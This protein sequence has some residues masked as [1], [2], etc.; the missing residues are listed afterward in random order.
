MNEEKKIMENISIIGSGNVGRRIGIYFSKETPSLV[1]FNDINKNV[2]EEL[3][4]TGYNATTDMEHTLK[5]SDISF[6]AVPTPIADDGL[7]NTSFLENAFVSIGKVL[8]YK[9]SY[10]IFVLKSTVTPGTTEELIIPIIE[11]YSGKIEGKDFGVVFNPEFLTVI[12]NTWTDDKKFCVNS[13]NEGR[14]V[15]GEGKNKKAG[16]IIE[17]FYKGINNYIPV[18]RTDYKTAEM[19]KLV[20][21]NRLALAISFSNEIF[22]SCK[23]MK[24]RGMDIDTNFIIRSMSMDKRIGMYGSIFGKAWGGPCFLKDTVALETFIKNKTGKYPDLISGSVKINDEM[25]EIYD[26][27]E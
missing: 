15:I 22:L 21:N 9:N 17:A 26:I 12:S 8:K 3:E 11:K 4:K 7:Y 1:I 14:I 20:A 25:K 19:T 16:D 13:E 23:E 27:R 6:I 10:H 18:L 2:I 5:S 24:N